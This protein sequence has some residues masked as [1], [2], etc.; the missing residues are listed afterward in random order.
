LQDVR[1]A[2]DRARPGPSDGAVRA[3]RVARPFAFAESPAISQ[4]L[5]GM[6]TYVHV[7]LP[8]GRTSGTSKVSMA[9]EGQ[10]SGPAIARPRFAARGEPGKG[11]QVTAPPAAGT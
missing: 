9:I 4:P 7:P 5:S 2:G 11:S 1:R 10:L 8:S 6:A 3:R